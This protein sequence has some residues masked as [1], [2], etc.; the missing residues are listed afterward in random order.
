MLFRSTA[1]LNQAVCVRIAE[2]RL[3]TA[4]IEG[5]RAAVEV[6]STVVAV[7]VVA[8]EVVAIDVVS[9]DVIS[10]DVIGID[11]VGVEVVAVVVVVSIDE[12]VGVGDVGVVVV[13]N[14]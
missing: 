8:V 12:R 4:L 3:V 7:D 10:V 9:V 5:G 6:I 11:V 14:G 13:H 2:L 1:L